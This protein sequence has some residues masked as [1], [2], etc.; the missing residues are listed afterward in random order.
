MVEGL[1]GVVSRLT[2]DVGSSGVDGHDFGRE[3]LREDL[4][5]ASGVLGETRR[6]VYLYSG[7]AAFRLRHYLARVARLSRDDDTRRLFLAGSVYTAQFVFKSLAFL[8][9]HSNASAIPLMLKSK[10]A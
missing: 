9:A 2:V 4:S 7:I 1:W 3:L 5:S 10:N 6:R 8:H